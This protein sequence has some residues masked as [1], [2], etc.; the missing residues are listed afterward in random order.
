MV[1]VGLDL[2]R[3]RLDVCVPGENGEQWFQREVRSRIRDRHRASE[4]TR[5]TVVG[6]EAP[7]QG[8]EIRPCELP[9]KIPERT[10]GAVMTAASTAA[11]PAATQ[12]RKP[13]R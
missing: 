2:R 10:N 3:T 4:L 13:S 11:S 6:G 8:G 5:Q 9:F 1:H 7:H 12:V